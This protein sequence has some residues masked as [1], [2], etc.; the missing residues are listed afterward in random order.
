MV[1]WWQGLQELHS[2]CAEWAT[3]PVTPLLGTSSLTSHKSK[4]VT[5]LFADRHHEVDVLKCTEGMWDPKH[6]NQS[7]GM[8]CAAVAAVQEAEAPA[9]QESQVLAI[10]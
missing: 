9:R 10:M 3:F 6:P 5:V 8:Y 4:A 2:D 7:A 1:S